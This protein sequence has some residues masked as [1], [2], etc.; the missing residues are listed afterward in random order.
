ML[1]FV[2]LKINCIHIPIVLRLRV[3]YGNQTSEFSINIQGSLYDL[4]VF[5]SQYMGLYIYA[6]VFLDMSMAA[7]LPLA[8][9]ARHLK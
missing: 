7:K 6:L 1:N 3:F 9:T 5:A 2:I 8:N 4:C